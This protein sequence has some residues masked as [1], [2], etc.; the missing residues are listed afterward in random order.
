MTKI[1]IK[2]EGCSG[3]YLCMLACSFFITE[4]KE[5]NLSKA[6]IKISMIDR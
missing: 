1:L 3:C 6:K 5:F 4:E 2:E